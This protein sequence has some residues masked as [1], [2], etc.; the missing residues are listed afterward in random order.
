MSNLHTELTFL[1]SVTT[2]LSASLESG[3]YMTDEFARCLQTQHS[4][5]FAVTVIDN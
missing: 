5:L 2:T 3:V 4:N 1:S